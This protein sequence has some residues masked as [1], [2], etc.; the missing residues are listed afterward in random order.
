M[1]VTNDTSASTLGIAAPMSTTNGACLTP[2]S[3]SDLLTPRKTLDHRLLHDRGQVA[4]L[5]ELVVERDH[6]DEVGQRGH[7]LAGGG[8]LAGGHGGGAQV[9]REVEE[10]GFDAPARSGLSLALA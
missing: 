10:V 5:V 3:F 2:R 8:V 4:R 9:V 6:L 1:F 7:R